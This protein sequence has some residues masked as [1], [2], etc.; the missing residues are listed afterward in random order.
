MQDD[1]LHHCEVNGGL[2]LTERLKQK[3]GEADDSRKERRYEK[4]TEDVSEG[5]RDAD[6]MPPK[7]FSFVLLWFSGGGS[8]QPSAA[9]SQTQNM[10]FFDARL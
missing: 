6:Q 8:Y 3:D 4:E 2:F 7:G 10:L 9:A 5:G 1:L